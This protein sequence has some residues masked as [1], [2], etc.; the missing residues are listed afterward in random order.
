MPKRLSLVVIEGRKIV[1]TAVLC[2]SERCCNLIKPKREP[3]REKKNECAWV[4][5]PEKRRVFGKHANKIL[6]KHGSGAT[7]ILYGFFALV[8]I[9]S[10]WV[11]N[12][13]VRW[14]VYLGEREL[15]PGMAL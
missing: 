4:I 15:K 10:R 12:K 13:D 7:E 2:W 9:G 1:E 3:D 14:C 8:G 11:D 6:E 5:A